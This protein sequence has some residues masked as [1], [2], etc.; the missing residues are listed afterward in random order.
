MNIDIESVKQALS[1]VGIALGILKQAKDLLPDG[2]KKDE[3]DEALERA[4]R[5]LKLAE[6]QTALG[7]EYELCRDHFPPEVMTS[8]DD[9]NWECPVCGNTKYTGLASGTFRVL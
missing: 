1:T 3:I 4:E 5:Q 9:V 6:S 2:S 8:K 7:M